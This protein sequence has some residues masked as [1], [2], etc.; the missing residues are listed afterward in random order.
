MR[1]KWN[2]RLNTHNPKLAKN[3]YGANFFINKAFVF[4]KFEVLVL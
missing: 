4:R 3:D 1:I 2:V